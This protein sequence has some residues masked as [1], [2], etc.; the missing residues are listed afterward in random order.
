MHTHKGVSSLQQI[1]PEL[2]ANSVLSGPSP[3][4]LNGTVVNITCTTGHL[5]PTGKNHTSFQFNGTSWI[6]EEQEFECL[7]AC[8]SDPPNAGV[9]I[10]RTYTGY[11]QWG[12]VASYD[13]GVLGLFP[14]GNATLYS[15]CLD[16]NW[17]LTDIPG[18]SWEHSSM[19]CL[20]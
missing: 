10:L 12:A 11:G 16:G 4:Y 8:T 7:K 14:D 5:S 9:G 1:L 2:P 6:I 20:V 3:P 19:I 15:R 17:S 18:C 13:C